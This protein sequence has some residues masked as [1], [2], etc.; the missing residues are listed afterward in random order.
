MP[1]LSITTNVPRDRLK[2]S[3]AVKELSSVVAQLTGKPEQVRNG[4]WACRPP[5]LFVPLT[6]VGPLC[7]TCA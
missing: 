6:S 7:S 5:K 4:S 2:A 3:E 1:T